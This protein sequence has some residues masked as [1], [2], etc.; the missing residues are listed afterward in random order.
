M[1]SFLPGLVSTIIPVYN[2][3]DFLRQSVASVLAQTYRPVEVIIVDDGSTDGVAGVA[4]A[5]AAAHPGVVFVHH[6]PNRGPGPARETGRLAARGEFIQY[7]DSDDLLLPEKFSL[8]VEALRADPSADLAGGVTRLVDENN[9][10]LVPVYKWTGRELD[11]LFPGLLVDRWW[12][13]HTPLY[14]R[15]LTDRIGPWTSLRYS[16][17]W[18]YDARA[19]ALGARI[20]RVTGAVS[21]HRTH[22]GPR[23][24]GHGRWLSPADQVRFFTSLFEGGRQAGV[25]FEAPEMAH[26]GRWVFAQARKAALVGESA[27]SDQL[28]ALCRR[29]LPVPPR[30]LRLYGLLRRLA[31][32]RLAARASEALRR[33]LPGRTSAQT[34]PFSWADAVP[35]TQGK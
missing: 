17:D 33:C 31:G 23:Q 35:H 8:Q 34:L 3:P 30:D 10:V 11:R 12:C 15:A 16:Q 13:T 19:G 14:R 6:L 1:S 21:H 4:D 32:P 9:A 20:A 22:G 26:F 28:L 27:A 25:T 2:R 29:A 7:L 18:E 5:L 24:T